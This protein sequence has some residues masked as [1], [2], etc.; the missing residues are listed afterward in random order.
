MTKRTPTQIGAA[1]FNETIVIYQ[2][3]CVLNI[4]IDDA[5]VR[6][7]ASDT[8][9]KFCD[10]NYGIAREGGMAMVERLGIEWNIDEL[11]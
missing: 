10:D 6:W 3:C 7:Y 8:Y 5:F 11:R 4:S 9:R 1:L 2:L